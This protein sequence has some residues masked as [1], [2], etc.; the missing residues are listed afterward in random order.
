MLSL[1]KI[2]ILIYGKIL[3]KFLKKGEG[4]GGGGRG[5]A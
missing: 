2:N 5:R 3:K 4:K 1:K